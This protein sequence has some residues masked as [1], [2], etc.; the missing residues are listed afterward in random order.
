MIWPRINDGKVSHRNETKSFEMV[1]N[2]SVIVM[3]CAL[4]QSVFIH[5]TDAWGFLFSLPTFEKKWF[6]CTYR[7]L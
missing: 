7:L 4:N 5:N 1:S 2:P 6:F 3:M